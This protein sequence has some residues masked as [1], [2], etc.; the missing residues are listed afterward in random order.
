MLTMFLCSS[1]V[2]RLASSSPLLMLG[3]FLITR[4]LLILPVFVQVDRTIAVF[5]QDVEEGEFILDPR[6][7]LA[8]ALLL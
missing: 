1:E 8:G 7:A 4:R 2:R 5:F 6:D 3:F